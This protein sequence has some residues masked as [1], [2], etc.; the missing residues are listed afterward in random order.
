LSGRKQIHFLGLTSGGHERRF[1]KEEYFSDFSSEDLV[2]T[3][4]DL[5]LKRFVA[6]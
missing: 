4:G 1:L 2:T 5:E 3:C 6:S